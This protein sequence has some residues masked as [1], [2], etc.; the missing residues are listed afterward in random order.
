MAERYIILTN[1]IYNGQDKKNC[2][3]EG[4]TTKKEPTM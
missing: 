3:F 2:V 1:Q 4:R